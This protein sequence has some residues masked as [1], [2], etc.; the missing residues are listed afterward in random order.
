M[1]PIR[2]YSHGY[3]FLTNV[4][5]VTKQWWNTRWFVAISFEDLERDCFRIVNH[6]LDGM[7]SLDFFGSGYLRI[8]RN[9][10]QFGSFD[11]DKDTN[12]LII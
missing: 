2:Q 12:C 4:D 5:T 3:G 1:I 6:T 7:N 10:L 9:K 8:I 11:T